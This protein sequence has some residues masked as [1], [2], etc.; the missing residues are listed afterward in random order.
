MRI[1]LISLLLMSVAT[2]PPARMMAEQLQPP[3]HLRCESLETPLGLD[4]AAPRLSWQL[5]DS[6]QGAKQTAYEIQVASRPELVASGHADVWDSGRVRSEQSVAVPYGGPELKPERRY[7]WR[8]MVWDKDGAAYP[9]SAA[10]W[11]ETGLMQGGWQAKWIGYELPEHR[12]IRESG[13][14]WITNAKQENFNA[15]GD[16]HHDFRLSFVLDQPVK[17]AH[18]YV[19]GKDT[20]A[21]WVMASKC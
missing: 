6:R 4:T 16:T 21:A 10:T 14:S 5:E 19:T 17:A 11:W 13:A 18:L 2:L 15:P 20:A 1:S 7:Y 12:A 9:A 8:V 3:S